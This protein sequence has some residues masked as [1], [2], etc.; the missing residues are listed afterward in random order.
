M[1]QDYLDQFRLLLEEAGTPIGKMRILQE[2]HRFRANAMKME[3]YAKHVRPLTQKIPEPVELAGFKFD[4]QS[5]IR[6]QNFSKLKL[7]DLYPYVMDQIWKISKNGY[8]RV[9]V[10][11]DQGHAEITFHRWNEAVLKYLPYERKKTSHPRTVEALTEKFTKLGAL[12]IYSQSI[13][14]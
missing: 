12:L 10:M 13:E 8:M 14:S 4:E 6:E 3:K 9:V 2:F 5:Y 7:P 1:D 11:Q